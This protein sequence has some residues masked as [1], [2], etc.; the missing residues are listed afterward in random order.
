MQEPE[1]GLGLHLGARLEPEE[2]S[3][4]VP[5]KDPGDAVSVDPIADQMMRRVG[6]VTV[7]GVVD[8]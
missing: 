3:P 7:P 4:R 6:L 1:S 8:Q 2:A 5:E